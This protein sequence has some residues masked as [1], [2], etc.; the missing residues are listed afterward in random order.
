M[1][2]I[3]IKITNMCRAAQHIV[4]S[5]IKDDILVRL[6]ELTFSFTKI[7]HDKPRYGEHYDIN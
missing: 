6:H 5:S 7:Y 3:I 2:N 1:G 4:L